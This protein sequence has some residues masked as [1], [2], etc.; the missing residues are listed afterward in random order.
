MVNRWLRRAPGRLSIP[1]YT[2]QYTHGVCM[3]VCYAVYGV[4][5]EF[6]AYYTILLHDT[7]NSDDCTHFTLIM[8]IILLE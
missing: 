5:S 4:N 2:A 7:L 1:M 3:Y 6:D 8:L